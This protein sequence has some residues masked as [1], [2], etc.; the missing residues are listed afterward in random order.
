MCMAFHLQ[1]MFAHC[2]PWPNFN[3]LNLFTECLHGLMTDDVDNDMLSTCRPSV[4][5]FQGSQSSRLALQIFLC[6]GV[7]C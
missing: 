7:V 4:H 5:E 3:H 6:F 1:D 2:D